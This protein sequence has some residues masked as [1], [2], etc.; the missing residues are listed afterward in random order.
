LQEGVQALVAAALGIGPAA[1]LTLV[2]LQRVR[3]L[4]FVP[5]SGVLIAIV[6]RGNRGSSR[7]R[8]PDHVRL[9]DE[10]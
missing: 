3:Q 5:L 7:D 1:G 9:P 6:T 8:L 2:L 4:L 10:S